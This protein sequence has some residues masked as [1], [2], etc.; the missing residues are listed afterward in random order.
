MTV[1]DNCPLILLLQYWSP[2]VSNFRYLS[3]TLLIFHPDFKKIST[4][5]GPTF[6]PEHTNF[7]APFLT[8]CNP[9]FSN[10][11]YELRSSS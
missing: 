9:K 1:I 10:F 2:E 4:I 6:L 3:F 5:K 7:A 8:K 11:T